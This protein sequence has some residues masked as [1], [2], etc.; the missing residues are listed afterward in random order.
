MVKVNTD[1]HSW[2]FSTLHSSNDYKRQ[3]TLWENLFR[4]SCNY[5]GECL[6]GR[7]FNEVLQDKDIF[8]GR[9][10]NNNRDINIWNFLDQCKM[11]DLG[12]KGRSKRGLKSI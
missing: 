9:G 4:I 11:L 10:I 2:I 1:P 7:A 3:T 6:I 8:G 12:F 5:Q